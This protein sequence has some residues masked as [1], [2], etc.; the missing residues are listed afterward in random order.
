MKKLRS[1]GNTAVKISARAAALLLALVLILCL[2]GCGSAAA[3]RE[4][5]AMDT[6]MQLKVYGGDAEKALDEISGLI[7]E[8]D[9]L[10]SAT[11]KGS[12]IYALNE[13]GSARV[14]EMTFDVISRSLAFSREIGGCFDLTLRPILRAWGFAGGEYR[15]P[16]DE[17]LGG[18]LASVGDGGIALDADTLTVALPEGAELDLG[19][20]A[21][22]YAADEAAAIVK[23]YGCTGAM[24]NL[25]SSTIFAVGEK[26]DGSKWRIA[27]K[28]PDG[29]GTA[30]VI[31]TSRCAVSTS[32]G[33]E[34]CFTGEDG[35][36]YWH[37]MD[38]LTGRPARNGIASVTVITDDAF[39]GD[40][41]STALFVMGPDGAESLYRERGGFEFIMLMEDGSIFLTPG[42]AEVFTP[43]GSF[44]NAEKRV[45]DAP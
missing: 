22:G 12:E 26:P 32:G 16:S 19:A 36:T 42:A 45:A 21:K 15:I 38:P 43:E 29:S 30:G 25:G 27:V 1:K 31:E 13:S 40:G 39:T 7:T 8:L 3:G 10:L 20:L 17:E 34:R 5:F 14:S 35:E 33:Y 6:F 24:L 9:R 2:P 23:R 28:A 44:A 11:D 37:I 18:L 41:L 4:L